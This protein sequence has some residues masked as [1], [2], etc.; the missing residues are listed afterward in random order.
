MHTI[1]LSLLR[2]R[3]SIRRFKNQPIDED[4]I[5]ILIEAAVRT[6]TSRA[7]N[8]WEFVVVTD[9][10][11]IKQMGSAKEHGSTFLSGAP[12]AFVVAADPDKSDVWVEDCSIAAMV[13]QLTAEELGLGSCWVQIR[14]R[15]HDADCSAEDFL[16]KLLGLPS[17]LVVE[18][19]IAIGYPNE[20]KEGHPATILPFDQVHRNKFAL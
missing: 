17:S 15:P 13:I 8:P 14:L 7:R 9:A 4:K 12:L 19:V 5:N 11:L 6:P 2:K 10:Q 1:I 16:K 20:V 3:R 18:C